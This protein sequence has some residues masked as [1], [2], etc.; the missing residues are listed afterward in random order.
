MRLG[1]KAFL[2][3][4]SILLDIPPSLSLVIKFSSVFELFL[5]YHP[6]PYC[7]FYFK[8]V[9]QSFFLF[10]PAHPPLD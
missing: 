5:Y 4:Q 8:T 7:R 10:Q 9:V 3:L 2:L 6:H 1:V